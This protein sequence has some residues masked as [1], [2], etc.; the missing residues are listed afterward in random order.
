MNDNSEN[1]IKPIIDS[2]LSSIVVSSEL[3]ERIRNNTLHKKKTIRKPL[4]FVAA[5]SICLILSIPVMAAKIPAFNGLLQVV[6]PE[7]ALFL[8]PVELVS[9]DKGIKMEVVAAMNDDETA[10]VYLTLQD[11]TGERV[12]KTVDLY[13]YSIN[14]ANIHSHELVDYNE[15]TGTATIRMI[16]NG[17]NKLNGK[18]VTVRVSSFLSGK[19]YY[20]EVNTLIPLA[21]VVKETPETVQLDMNHIPGGGGDL[22]S[23]LKEKGI[24]DI[25]KADG[26]EI[27]LP[28]IDFAHISNIGY[29]D[30][31]LHVQMK[32]DASVDNHGGLYLLD[33]SG[34]KLY[35]SNISFGI[36]EAGNTIYGNEYS[37]YIFNVDASQITHYTLHGFFVKNN[38]YTEGNWT[39]TFKLEAVDDTKKVVQH[40]KLDEATLDEVIIQKMG[41]TITGHT[42]FT[43]KIN[44]EM[45]ML[46]GSKIPYNHRVVQETDGTWRAKYFPNT[47][48]EM[49]NMKEL[50]INSEVI[51]V[52]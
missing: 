6:S 13:N 2:R 26:K 35:A 15:A 5:I 33:A 29:I 3:E 25:L 37:E 43:D 44:V 48:V 41:I 27:V 51:H 12:D 39:T 52:Q 40:V 38:N 16:A 7:T 30:E 47:P 20:N 50:R 4:S 34:E 32:W 21:D 22:Y 18:K 14:G 9:E 49:K 1:K 31:R 23:E 45:L 42:D 36:D 24:I 19:Q 28:E 17:G 10:I 46:D 11:L 8:Q